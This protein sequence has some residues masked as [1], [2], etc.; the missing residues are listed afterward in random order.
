MRRQSKALLAMGTV[1]G[2]G[3]GIGLVVPGAAQAATSPSMFDCLAFEPTLRV[4]TDQTA[5]TAAW[6]GYLE[7]TIDPNLTIDGQFGPATEAATKEFQG[8]FNATQDGVVGDETWGWIAYSCDTLTDICSKQ[9][10]Y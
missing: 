7:A 2:L 5:C 8:R 10:S 6:Q 3:L 1:V 4:G 9:F